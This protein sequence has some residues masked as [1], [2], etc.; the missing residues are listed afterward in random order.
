M[1]TVVLLILLAGVAAA[2]F[3]IWALRASCASLRAPG[4][5]VW[6][7]LGQSNAANSAE[8]RHRGWPGVWTFDGRRCVAAADP[9]PGA[10]GTAGSLWVPLANRVVADG[11]APAVLI[12]SRAEGAT[13]VTQWLP[14]GVLFGRALA[15]IAGLERAGLRVSRVLWQQGEADA[16]MGTPA[17]VYA[18][19]L[20]RVTGALH[21][22]TGAPVHIAVSGWCGDVYAPDIRAAQR[23]LADA[24]AM[25]GGP[26]T[27]I[28]S[29]RRERCHFDA[30]GQ[31]QAAGLWRKA[32]AFEL[33]PG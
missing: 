19:R 29:G 9:L 22:A 26:D 3:D 11:G 33:P 18:D 8:V 6:L 2:G 25:R 27:D 28:V 24:A 4:T 15:A 31:M 20:R 32:L 16:I 5:E 7:A 1:R 14:G 30:A 13:A 17:D 23:A 12:V 21:R 10:S